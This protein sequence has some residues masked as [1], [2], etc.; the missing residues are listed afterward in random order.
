[1]TD[2]ALPSRASVTSTVR[3]ALLLPR[4]AVSLLVRTRGVKLPDQP[5][6]LFGDRVRR[7]R[8]VHHGEVRHQRPDLQ[9][10]PA[11]LLQQFQ[12]ALALPREE[13][14]RRRVQVDSQ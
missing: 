12:R 14:L 1:M 4:T 5:R 9:V 2:T 13:D 3:P 7:P 10:F 6:Y 8:G 11:P